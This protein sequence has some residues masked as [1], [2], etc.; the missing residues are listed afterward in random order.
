MNIFSYPFDSDYILQKKKRLKKTLLS[1]EVPRTKVNIAVLGGS[2][3]DDII[4]ILELFLLN[5]ELEPHFYKSEYNQFWNDSV[6]HN[7]DLVDFNPDIIFIHT[8]S[9]NITEYTFDLSLTNEEMD[10][11]LQSQYLYFEAM[12][13][14]LFE[15]YNCPIIQNNF[16]L[17]LYRLMGNKDASS[18]HGKLN[19][20]TKLNQKFYDFAE[21]HDNFYINDI[22]YLSSVYGI[23]KWAD[24]LYWYMYKY[25]LSIDA[26]PEFSFNLANI[27]KS[28]YG[29]NR[30]MMVLDLDNTLWGGVI[31]DDGKEHIEIG[32][33]TPVSQAYSEFQDYIKSHKNLGILLS[34]CSK[35]DMSN[36]LDGLS[37]PDNILKVEDFIKIKANWE[38]KDINIA[39]ICSEI[40]LT[41]SSVVFIDDNPA[42]RE[43]VYSQNNSIWTPCIENV[44]NYIETIDRNGYF[45]LTTFSKDD[46]TRN[47]MYKANIEREN[48]N[49]KFA[50]YN[51]YLLSLNMKATIKNF[52]KIS[53]SRI[54]QLTNKSNQFNLT[55]KRY[56]E[57]DMSIIMNDTENYITLYG[58][59]SD[60]FGDNGIVSVVIGHKLNDELHIDLWLMSCRVLKRDMEFA[61]LD[62]LVSIARSINISCIWGYYLKTPKNNM[63][64]DLYE[65]FGFDL[66]NKDEKENSSWKLYV[67]NYENK[68][69][70]IQV[71]EED[72]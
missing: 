37:H 19:F 28:I 23:S 20:I 11:K 69:N 63:V 52:D 72:Y 71:L 61:M 47:A 55:T 65:K 24:P 17:P 4:T 34:V 59:L 46:L 15:K 67:E 1:K 5:Y 62:K 33:E 53:I 9:R 25:A 66:I 58:K 43:I 40:N 38:N 31:G 29:K 42:E 7:Q 12:W 56:T 60:K 6:F 26:I 18:P 13:K 36:A 21:K 22:N 32:N 50:N 14:S 57:S 39:E 48:S 35:N 49:K 3:T 30:K 10:K 45:E 54:A 68:N 64:H 16:E 27:V 70:V 8:T 44:E 2:T 51:D 41:P